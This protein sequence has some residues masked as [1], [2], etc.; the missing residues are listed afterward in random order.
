MKSLGA[1]IKQ[2]LAGIAKGAML[3][4]QGFKTVGKWVAAP[5]K[6][7]FG[8]NGEAIPQP[9]EME[10][11]EEKVAEP[12]TAPGMDMA[13][14][15]EPEPDSPEVIARALANRSPVRKG[16]TVLEQWSRGTC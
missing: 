7:V 4:A 3:A 10:L 13:D 14:G 8:R 11:V 16:L 2:L 15:Q 12:I 5:F 6:Y 1:A 9:P